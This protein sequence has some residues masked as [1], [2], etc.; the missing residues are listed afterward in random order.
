MQ[1]QPASAK[2]DAPAD[3]LETLLSPLM[4]GLGLQEA[5]DQEKLYQVDYTEVLHDVQCKTNLVG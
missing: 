5:I 1:I 3:A 4:D 2:V